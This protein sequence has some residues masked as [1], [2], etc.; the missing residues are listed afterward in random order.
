MWFKARTAIKGWGTWLNE[1]LWHRT[2]GDADYKTHEGNGKQVETI[3]ESGEMLDWWHMRKGRWPET[4]G[5]LLFKI[6]HEI[7]KTKKT[8]DETPLTAVW[9]P[10]ALPY[11][12]SYR[13]F[14]LRRST[15]YHHPFSG[16]GAFLESI[17]HTRLLLLIGRFDGL[18]VHISNGRK[19][20]WVCLTPPMK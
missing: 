17:F 18:N 12:K 3:R 15:N 5:E 11:Q 19:E 9:Q 2:K 14:D 4:R 20:G 10:N 1:I 16:V 7:H 13:A 8:Q 6:K